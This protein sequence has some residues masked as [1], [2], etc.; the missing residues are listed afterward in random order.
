M[1]SGQTASD[2]IVAHRN[3]SQQPFDTLDFDGSDD[4]V[5]DRTASTFD[6]DGFT[7]DFDT[8]PGSAFAVATLCLKGPLFQVRNYSKDNSGTDPTA[9]SFTGLGFAPLAVF[10]MGTTQNAPPASAVTDATVVFGASDGSTEGFAMFF[11]DEGLATSDCQSLSK[12]DKFFAGST[13]IGSLDFEGDLTSLDADGFS[14]NWTT[15]DTAARRLLVAAIG[16]AAVAP[17]PPLTPRRP[18]LKAHLPR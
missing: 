11:D 3:W 16:S 8:A 5:G 7:I 17:F 4:H 1:W 6:S 2:P 12:T 14:V 18:N 9:E 13:T 10:C 15:N